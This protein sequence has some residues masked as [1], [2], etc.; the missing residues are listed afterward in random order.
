[1]NKTGPILIVDDDE[2]DQVL[3]QLVFNKLAYPNKLLF[4]AHGQAALDFLRQTDELPLLILSDMNMPGVNGL[5]LGQ[6][7]Q[8]DARLRS[9]CTPL[10]FFTTG[11]T[12]NE[13]EQACRLS[14]QGF[15]VKPASI[16]ELERMMALIVSYWTASLTPGKLN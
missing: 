3:L 5:E 2:D 10:L 14:P 15:F 1:M 4:F 8:Q 7:I 9:R 12:Q 11:S 13:V 6:Q 16:E